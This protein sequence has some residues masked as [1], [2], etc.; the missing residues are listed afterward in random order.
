MM[1]KKLFHSFIHA[2]RGL[3]FA[4]NTQ[5]NFRIHLLAFG[6]VIIA[7]CIYSLNLVEWV[8]ILGCCCLVIT[9]ELINTAIEELCN[10]LHPEKDS[11]IGKVKDIAA[12]AVLV[13]AIFAFI[14]GLLI[15]GNKI[16]A[17]F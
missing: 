6:L 12:A 15:F 3:V 8:L 4:F 13:T 16:I 2:V 9:T 1:I 14:V 17:H 7:G 10:K 5:Q 11:Q